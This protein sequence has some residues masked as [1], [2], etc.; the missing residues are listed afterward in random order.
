MLQTV[1]IQIR[2]DKTPGLIW[3]QTDPHSDCIPER[4]FSKKLLILKMTKKHAKFPSTVNSE[5]FAR[6]LFSRNF[7]YTK[8]RENKILAKLP[9]H[10]VD[11]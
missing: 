2:P 6:V 4:I 1:C 3:M 5:N 10:S 11:Y 9:N 8:I 7:V